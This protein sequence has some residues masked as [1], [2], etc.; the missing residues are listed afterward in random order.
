M[1]RLKRNLML[2]ILLLAGCTAPMQTVRGA[3]PTVPDQTFSC[4][5]RLL[6]QMEYRVED[7]DLDGGFIL[8]VKETGNAMSEPYASEATISI[9]PASN[10]DG[11]EVSVTM[12]RTHVIPSEDRISAGMPALGPVPVFLGPMNDEGQRDLDALTG[13][14]TR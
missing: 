3:R 13:A 6:A 11:S 10:G 8:E 1:F 2:A 14:C 12:R 7:S 5:L 9:A 4:Y